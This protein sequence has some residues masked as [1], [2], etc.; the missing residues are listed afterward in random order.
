MHCPGWKLEAGTAVK[1][2]ADLNHVMAVG[3]ERRNKSREIGRAQQFHLMW[4]ERGRRQ[5]ARLRGFQLFIERGKLGGGADFVGKITIHVSRP[6]KE[7][8]LA[9]CSSKICC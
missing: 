9:L 2:K 5:P 7:H 8:W 3:L 4:D 1:H 6:C